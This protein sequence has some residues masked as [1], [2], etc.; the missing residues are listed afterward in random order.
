L[1]ISSG[2]FTSSVIT[3]VIDPNLVRHATRTPQSASW[4]RFRRNPNYPANINAKYKVGKSPSTIQSS[5]EK[6]GYTDVAWWAADE[7]R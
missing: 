2:S 1:I 6:D 5:V 7:T 4:P 3:K